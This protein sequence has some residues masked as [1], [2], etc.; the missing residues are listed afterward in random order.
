MHH[1]PS[2][3]RLLRVS[4]YVLVTGLAMLLVSACSHEESDPP[5]AAQSWTPGDSLVVI[6]T[7]MDAQCFAQHKKELGSKA[8]HEQ[9]G[10]FDCSGQFVE[11]GA[12]A[13]LLEK[14][15]TPR[16]EATWILVSVPQMLRNHMAD[17]ARVSGQFRSNGVLVPH[18]IDIDDDGEWLRIF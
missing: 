11:Q 17:R 13:A 1:L 18:R 8:A 12:P 9:A 2:S 6:G 3:R 14:S 15:S 4:T 5:A 10:T 7:L 16:D